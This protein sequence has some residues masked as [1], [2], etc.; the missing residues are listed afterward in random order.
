MRRWFLSYHSPDQALAERLKAA[1]ERKDDSASRVSSQMQLTAPAVAHAHQAARSCCASEEC[2]EFAA[3]HSI[4]SSAR[5]RNDSGT[6]RPNAFAVVRLTTNSNL[7]GCS[8]GGER[9]G[10]LTSLLRVFQGGLWLKVR[11]R[12]V[13]GVSRGKWPQSSVLRVGGVDRK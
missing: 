4:I 7:V 6:V 8:I 9:Y 5:S 12:A 1:I 13:Q 10:R 3:D 11:I 2:D